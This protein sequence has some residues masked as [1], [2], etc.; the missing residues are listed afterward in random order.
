[1]HRKALTSFIL[2]LILFVCSIYS[3]FASAYAAE[4][5]TENG[6][7]TVSDVPDNGTLIVAAYDETNTLLGCQLYNSQSETGTITAN[8]AEDLGEYINNSNITIKQFLWDMETLKPFTITPAS[9]T[10]DEKKV[11]VAYFSCTNN[12]KGIAKHILNAIDADEYEI[13]P[14]IPYTTADLNYSNSS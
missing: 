8:Y 5:I 7:I 6:T 4:Y 12:T 2:P 1:M 11:L 14:E 13:V 3:A 10:S 9:E